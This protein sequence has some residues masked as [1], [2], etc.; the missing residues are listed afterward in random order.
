L[1]RL[2]KLQLYLLRTLLNI[3]LLKLQKKH[4]ELVSLKSHQSKL[5]LN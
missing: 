1:Q 3:D 4:I 2:Q 5:K